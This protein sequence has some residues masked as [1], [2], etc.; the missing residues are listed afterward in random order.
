MS[1]EFAEKWSRRTKGAVSDYT[2]GVQRVSEAPGAK[3]AARADAMLSGVQEA[4]SSGKWQE[5]VSAVS[6]GD[7]QNAAVSK[8]AGRIAAGV[9][10]AQ[11]DMARFGQELLTAVDG[12]VAEVEGMPNDNLED[13]INRMV[14]FSRRMSQFKRAP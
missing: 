2:R 12:A 4:I 10:A 11:P 14:A 5:R 13:R 8:G 1:T 3:A 9:D 7:W 6:L